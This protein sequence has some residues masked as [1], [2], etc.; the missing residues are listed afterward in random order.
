MFQL[1]DPTTVKLKKA[2]T[3]VDTYEEAE[4]LTLELRVLW[5]TS[6]RNLDLIRKGMREYFFCDLR[7]EEERAQ[8]DLDLPI[9]D[10]PNLKMPTFKYPQSDGYELMGARVEIA[11]GID[12][13]SAIVLQLCKV[14]KFQF[15]PIEGGSAHI[16][17]SISSSAELDSNTLGTLLQLQKHEITITQTMPDVEES[18]KPL[19]EQDVFPGAPPSDPKKPLTADD[20]FLSAHATGTGDNDG[21]DTG[22][23]GEPE[24]A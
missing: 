21:D 14:H 8:A 5:T 1:T 22:P 17:Y 18:T 15:T 7:P 19:T 24:D 4:R 16:E 23:T 10:L 20:V 3:T 11:H 12:E 13:T 2:S 9:D 6:N